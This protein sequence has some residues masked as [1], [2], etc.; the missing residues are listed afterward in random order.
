MGWGWCYTFLG[1]IFVLATSLLWVEY[2]W[3]MGWRE[4]RRQRKERE[5]AQEEQTS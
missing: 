2:K 4:E 5:K 3:G 1:L